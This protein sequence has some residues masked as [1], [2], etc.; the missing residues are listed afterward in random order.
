MKG[1]KI[2]IISDTHLLPEEMVASNDTFRR[3]MQTDRKLLAESEGLL[4]AALDMIHDR[5]SEILFVTGDM[6]KDGELIS[7]Q[8]FHRK[9]K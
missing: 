4:N 6:T 8:V 7:H 1:T 5:D 9:M 2:S 3:H